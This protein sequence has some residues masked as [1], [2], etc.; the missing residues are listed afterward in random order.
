[1]PTARKVDTPGSATVGTGTPQA[2]KKTV[3]RGR[4]AS[5]RPKPRKKPVGRTYRKTYTE[6]DVLEAVRLVREEEFSCAQA[7]L[8]LNSIK[9]NIVPRM[10]LNDRMHRENPTARP[11]VGRPQE[12][13][14]AVEEALVGCLTLCAEFQYPMRK[15]D[16][17]D[18]VQVQYWE[19]YIL[20]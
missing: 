8:M 10:T 5:A 16:L 4:P 18:L 12:I 15:R 2:K 17:Q 3:K 20:Q 11:Q 7:A 6:E 1:M 19:Q 13:S 14:P 9:K